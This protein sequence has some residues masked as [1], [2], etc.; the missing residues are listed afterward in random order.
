MRGARILIV[1]DE[2]IVAA[3]LREQLTQFGY[4]VEGLARSGE[5]ALRLATELLPDL[6]LMDVRLQGAMDGTEA[7]REIQR[8]T[9]TPVVY[10]TAFPGV[11]IRDP[12]RMQPSNLCVVKP[13][14]KS[15]LWNIIEAALESE[16]TPMRPV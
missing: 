10:L 3:D 14:S 13:F 11:F 15:E 2:P 8:K 6:V 1:E 9:G 16:D 7:A 4:S 5:E 12:S